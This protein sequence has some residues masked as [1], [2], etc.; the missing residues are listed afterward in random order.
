[1]NLGLGGME[2]FGVSFDSDLSLFLDLVLLVDLLVDGRLELLNL[3]FLGGQFLLFLVAGNLLLNDLLLLSLFLDLL[4]L[5]VDDDISNDDLLLNM[6]VVDLSLLESLRS[7]SQVSSGGS[8]LGDFLLSLGGEFLDLL[9]TSGD[10]GGEF[11]DLLLDLGPLLSGASL[12]LELLLLSL[13]DVSC[14][15]GGLVVNIS[16]DIHNFLGNRRDFLLQFSGL[17]GQGLN[18]GGGLL[19][20]GSKIGS[21][22]FDQSSDLFLRLD[23]SGVSFFTSLI[24]LLSF[25]LNLAGELGLDLLDLVLDVGDLSLVG[26]GLGGGD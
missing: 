21:L 26:S 23:S 15:L 3:L 7:I 9:L 1:M 8:L 24:G 22:L 4:L 12:D 2:V 10:L 6:L 18:L 16:L 13:V 14:G 25:L 17:G 19:M 11:I 20:L 5:G